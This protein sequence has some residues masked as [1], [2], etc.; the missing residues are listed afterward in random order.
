[1]SCNW[2][3][4]E[5]EAGPL[6]ERIFF[7]WRFYGANNLLKHVWE[8]RDIVPCDRVALCVVVAVKSPED[9]SS[10]CCRI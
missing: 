6:K 7:L 1:M 9:E 10:V 5:E 8:I 4:E 3:E 2:A